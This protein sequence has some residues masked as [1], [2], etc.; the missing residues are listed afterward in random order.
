MDRDGVLQNTMPHRPGYQI[1]AHSAS[2]ILS[3]SS[4]FGADA[5]DLESPYSVSGN[6]GSWGDLQ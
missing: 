3:A 2:L 4:S 6:V 5:T 1:C